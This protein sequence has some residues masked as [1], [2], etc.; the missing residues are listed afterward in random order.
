MFLDLEWLKD[1]LYSRRKQMKHIPTLQKWIFMTL[2]T[3]N[4]TYLKETHRKLTHLQLM[5][6]ILD[7]SAT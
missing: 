1:A 2:I 3:L 7:F 5:T 6:Q 4:M